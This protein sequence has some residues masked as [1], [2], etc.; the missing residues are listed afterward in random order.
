ML[1]YVDF[2]DKLVLGSRNSEGE[3]GTK[4]NEAR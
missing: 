3:P 4:S 1:N 2:F